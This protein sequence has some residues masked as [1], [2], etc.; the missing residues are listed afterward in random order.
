LKNVR[1]SDPFWL[2]YVELVRNVIIPYQWEALNDRIPDAE[3]SYAARN[4]R[5]A[6]GL[7]KGEFGGYDFQD[8]DI[9][10]W[11]E[12]VGYSLATHPDPKLEAI[13]DD[14]I[15]VIEKAQQP[16]GYLDTRFIIKEPEKRWTNLH[17]CHEL[18]V[19]GHMMEAAVAYYKGTGKRKLL[20]VMC[21]AADHIADVFGS[22]P[23][24]IRGYDGHQ[25]IELALVKLYEA[26][27]NEKYLK[28]SKF[29]IDERGTEPNFF[30]KEWEARGGYSHWA[31]AIVPLPDFTYNQ[32]H[33]PVREQEAAAGHAVRAV[34]MCSG[35]ADIAR[36]TGDKQ[37]FEACKR[38]WGN[39]VSRQMYITG[40]IG[41]TRHGE[42]FTFDYDLPSGTVYA[43]TCA[44]V[45]LIFFAHRMLQMEQDSVYADVIERALYNTVLGSMA[46]DGRHFFYVNPLEVWPE[47]SL[48]DPGKHHVKPVRQK[49]FGCACC[50][51]NVARLLAS[52][53]QYIYS[54]QGNRVFVHLYIGGKTEIEVGGGKLRLRQE[55]RYPWDGDVRLCVD[56]A[57][58]EAVSLAIRI[59]GWCR[60]W[61]VTVNEENAEGSIENGYVALSRNWKTGDQIMLHLEMPV[62]LIQGNPKVRANNG[63]VAIQRG[64]L[65]YCLE[66]TDNGCNLSALSL[67]LDTPLVAKGDDIL[68][69]GGVAITGKA[70][71]ISEEG[72]KDALY[73]PYTA[74]ET[75]V[76]IKA[77]PYFM[78]GNRGQGEM[79]VWIRR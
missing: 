64:P 74:D 76:D 10:K 18:Y 49:W 46:R 48:K 2:E 8:S 32:A 38:L 7:E 59:P 29:F 28:L 3:P 63:R 42:A 25:E 34:Y 40:G 30:K 12:A 17:E 6:A 16:D 43:E 72:W 67:D 58:V 5:I 69:E 1:I 50:P 24:Q 44:S 78:W 75:K 33:K 4:F 71:R 61:S 37:L 27:G 47:A 15:E 52:L 56:S 11:L 26:T 36:E 23:G 62:E 77:V 66:E 54:V 35:M 31:K 19:A 39:M 9:A 41:A 65:V 55:N 60:R 70:A 13:A 45:G 68:S 14:F 20:D 53:P 51:P 73:R 21:R 22:E 79:L 57:P